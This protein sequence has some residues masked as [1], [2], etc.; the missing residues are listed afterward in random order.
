M[1]TEIIFDLRT[2]EQAVSALME[3]GETLRK[4]STQDESE[5]HEFSNLSN[6]WEAKCIE[7]LKRHLADEYSKD[8][9]ES[10]KQR[11]NRFIPGHSQPIHVK[12]QKLRDD[13]LLGI[14]AL[15]E[16]S[17]LV[18]VSDILVKPGR[19]LEEKRSEFT[20]SRKRLFMLEKLSCFKDEE[21][22]DLNYICQ[23]NGVSSTEREIIDNIEELKNQGL[24][25][26]PGITAYRTCAA[27]TT[28]GREYLEETSRSTANDETNDE[29]DILK[30]RLDEI[31]ELLH[32]NNDGNEIIFEELMEMKE[33]KLNAKN[34]QQ[35]LKGKLIDLMRNKAA[36]FTADA[37][38]DCFNHVTKDFNLPKLFE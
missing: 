29:V 32:R 2:F 38:K 22:H 6:T 34:W 15:R 19:I 23:A 26:T 24:V 25:G 27:I 14:N 9:I 17:G 20:I 36:A 30:S 11:A 37:A 35:L 31:I 33:A 12:V 1:D 10:F 28:R 13:A 16:I 7:M 21:Y 4:H 3:E 18:S 8:F 5:L